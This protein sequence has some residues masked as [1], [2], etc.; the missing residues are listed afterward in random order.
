MSNKNTQTILPYGEDGL[1]IFIAHTAVFFY[2]YRRITCGISY[3][4]PSFAD[5]STA[6]F[7]IDISSSSIIFITNIYYTVY[8]YNTIICCITY[9]YTLREL[10][11]PFARQ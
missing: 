9:E 3:K 1:S 6:N 5:S 4:L 2:S 8:V 11:K 10:Y 7:N